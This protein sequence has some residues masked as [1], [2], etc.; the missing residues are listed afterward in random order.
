MKFHESSYSESF[1]L[2]CS[3][4]PITHDSQQNRISEDAKMQKASRGRK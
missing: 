3:S 4:E 2:L 1:L